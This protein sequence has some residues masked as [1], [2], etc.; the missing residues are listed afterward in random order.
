MTWLQ[1]QKEFLLSEMTRIE[2]VHEEKFRTIEIR[3]S[4]GKDALVT[5]FS[6][7]KTLFDAQNLAVADAAKKS[8][9]TFSKQL[10][11]LE[12]LTKTSTGALSEKVDGIE[13][14]LTTSTSSNQGAIDN[15]TR[16]MAIIILIIMLGTF[17]L[18]IYSSINSSINHNVQLQTK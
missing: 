11:A 3:F 1:S 6:S 5:A 14:R 13:K 4:E 10:F 18:S 16:I 9:D 17:G 2:K 15:T 7:Q 12:T 8:E